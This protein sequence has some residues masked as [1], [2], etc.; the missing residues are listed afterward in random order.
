MFRAEISR[1]VY[2]TFRF[3][4]YFRQNNS[5][6]LSSSRKLELLRKGFFPNREII[7]GLRENDFSNYISDYQENVRAVHI[8]KPLN[9]LIN[10]K[11]IF[12][13]LLKP[14]IEV[15]ET[16]ALIENGKIV[17][18]GGGRSLKSW[19][20]VLE[21]V[22]INAP[23]I[24]KPIGGDGGVGIL[25]VSWNLDSKSFVLNQEEVKEVELLSKLQRLEHYMISEFVKQATYSQIIYPHSVNTVRLL[26]M[27]DPETGKAFIVA[28]AHRIGNDMSYPVDNCA[29]GGFT[30][31][32]DKDTG[33]L[34]RAVSVKKFRDKLVWHEVHPDTNER[35]A[36]VQIPNWD[37][38]VRKVLEMAEN[39]SFV[40]YLGWDVVI[41]E[42]GFTV[43]E[44]NDGAD[45]KLHQVHEPLL[46]NPNVKSFYR[47][48]KVI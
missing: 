38:V 48:H 29:M 32:I 43:L 19:E 41:T 44:A 25:K 2:R 27:I 15:P 14:F 18:Y 3:L 4:Q 10:D 30:A 23:L 1:W 16:H 22:R 17:Q 13:E 28:A 36:G 40:P 37:L 12:P 21:F 35:I 33:I 34:G 47:F 5:K 45:L 31:Y 11:L 39:I 6:K 24:L 9:N 8:N 46:V 20:K 26:S 42:D 7:Y